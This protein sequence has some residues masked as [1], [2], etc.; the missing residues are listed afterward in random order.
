MND[1]CIKVAKKMV[2]ERLND[3][4]TSVI[5]QSIDAQL[6]YLQKVADGSNNDR[7]QLKL[8]TL[9]LYAV[10][11]FESTDQDFANELFKIQHV[12]DNM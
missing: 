6:D 12:V 8:I 2:G 5:F 1:E 11:E 9:G 3:F 10:R 4:P 7:S